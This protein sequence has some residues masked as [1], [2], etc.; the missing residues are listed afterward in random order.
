MDVAGWY[1]T[2]AQGEL[3][4]AVTPARAQD[5]RFGTGGRTGKLGNNGEVLLRVATVGGLPPVNVA[6]VVLNGTVTGPTLPSVLTIYPANESKPVASNLNFA[7]NQTV[8]NS[9]IVKASPDG[10][11]KIHNLRGDTHV[12]VD[13]AGWFGP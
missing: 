11:V 6:A 5:T 7:A 1:T 3:F 2:G 10:R 4:H 9:A 12:I 13:V 8:P